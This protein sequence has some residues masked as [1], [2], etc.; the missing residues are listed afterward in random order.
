MLD[1]HSPNE[2][3]FLHFCRQMVQICPHFCC[4]L[5][6]LKTTPNISCLASFYNSRR[7]Y[8]ER[9][10]TSLHAFITFCATSKVIQG[11]IQIQKFQIVPLHNLKLCVKI[12]PSASA[13][14]INNIAHVNTG[15]HL[16]YQHR[17]AAF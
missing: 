17:D 8:T 10:G 6:I 1:C 3:M 2:V 9:L 12:V 15:V 16:I 4:F 5:S 11:R 7:K 13:D 14:N